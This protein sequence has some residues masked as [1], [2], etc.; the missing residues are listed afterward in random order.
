VLPDLS[1]LDLLGLTNDGT[2]VIAELKRGVITTGVVL[3]AL[4]YFLQL[5]AMSNAELVARVTGTATPHERAEG[6]TTEFDVLLAQP[7][8]KTRDHLLIVAGVG[9]DGSA[10]SAAVTLAEHGLDVPVRVVSFDLVRGTNGQRFLLREVDDEATRTRRTGSPAWSLDTILELAGECGVREGFQQILN[11][12]SRMGYHP[13]LKKTGLN[14]NLG[15]RAQVFW[16]KPVDGKIHIGYL[17]SNFPTLFGVD[18]ATVEE[19]LGPN[20]IDLSADEAVNQIMR[21]VDAVDEFRRA[22][23]QELDTA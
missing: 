19:R 20:W 1:R 17:I 16:V 6:V 12:L 21:W 3:Q 13:Y 14:F 5:A 18:E 22:A 8:E 9:T 2:W 10:E 7:D 11:K 4:H 23:V 15:S